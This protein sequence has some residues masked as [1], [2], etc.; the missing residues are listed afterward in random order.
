MPL[1]WQEKT[2]SAPCCGAARGFLSAAS[3]ASGRVICRINAPWLPSAR[4]IP[5]NSP[6]SA[7]VFRFTTRPKSFCVILCKACSTKPAPGGSCARPMPAM[8]SIRRWGSICKSWPRRT[9]AFI[10]AKLK[11]KASAPTPTPP[12]PW[13]RGNIWPWPTTMTFWLR[14][15]FS[16]WEKAFCAP[17]RI[18]CTAM[19]RCSKSGSTG[20]WWAILSPIMRRIIFCAAIISATWRCS[21]AVCLRLWAASAANA[22]AVRTMICS[23]G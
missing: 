6:L 20:P 22:M 1:R 7:C 9:G 21:A 13:Q 2:A 4:R 14:T 3:L 5:E 10:T 11:T 8:H 16:P 19:R 15:L 17:A 12:Q 23:C 18:F